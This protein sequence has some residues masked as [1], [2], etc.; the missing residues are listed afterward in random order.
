MLWDI[1]ALF[2]QYKEFLLLWQQN[3]MFKYFKSRLKILW[4]QGIVAVY[5]IICS[6]A[7]KLI[8]EQST[9]VEGTYQVLPSQPSLPAWTS[10]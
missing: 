8:R 6:S 3:L 9:H 4:K 10:E 5:V 7:Q 1:S 2:L